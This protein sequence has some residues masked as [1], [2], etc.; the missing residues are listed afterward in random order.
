MHNK[1]TNLIAR[2]G[3]RIFW[4]MIRPRYIKQLYLLLKSCDFIYEQSL[5]QTKLGV[6]YH[7][8]NGEIHKLCQSYS[9]TL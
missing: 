1:L 5:K 8:D 6:H 7:H 2:I 4:S 3:K 9:T